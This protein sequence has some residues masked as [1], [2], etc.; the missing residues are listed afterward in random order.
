MSLTF[1]STIHCG[2][3]ALSPVYV[4]FSQGLFDSACAVHHFDLS[5]G[6]IVLLLH[7]GSFSTCH[8]SFF[9]IIHTQR[10]TYR[11]KA[12]SRYAAVH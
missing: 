5:K 3:G 11:D 7:L 1:A 12:K 2:L 10:L 8:T 4:N 6:H 9:Y